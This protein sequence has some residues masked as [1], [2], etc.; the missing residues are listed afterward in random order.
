MRTKLEARIA[1]CAK[2]YE[3]ATAKLHA[4][5]AEELRELREIQAAEIENKARMLQQY[6]YFGRC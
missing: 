6:I 5:H 2:E 3:E 1:Q 4:A